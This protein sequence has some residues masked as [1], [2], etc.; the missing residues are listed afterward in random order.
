MK[1]LTKITFKISK[2]HQFYYRHF[3][4]GEEG[5]SNGEKKG[6]QGEGGGGY[7]MNSTRTL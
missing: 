4:R 6:V 2:S 3:L 7:A 5:R 1:E